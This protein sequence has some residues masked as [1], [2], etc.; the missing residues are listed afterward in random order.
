MQSIKVYDQN[1]LLLSGVNNL[2]SQ[3]DPIHK[4]QLDWL[5]ITGE[6]KP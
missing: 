4:I 3:Y 1:N 6:I 5:I 2:N